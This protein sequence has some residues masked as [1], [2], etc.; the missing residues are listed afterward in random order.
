[1]S[2]NNVSGVSKFNLWAES[3]STS[4]GD[5]ANLY[6]N[7]RH[8]VKITVGLSFALLDPSVSGPSDDEVRKGLSL[9]NNNDG[10][11]LQHLII[12]DKG[13]YTAIYEPGQVTKKTDVK[14][15]D[16]QHEIV[17]YLASNKTVNPDIA[18]EEVSVRLTYTDA[19]GD[20]YTDDMSAQGQ[21]YE[22]DYVK[23]TCYAQKKYTTSDFSLSKEEINATWHPNSGD[24]TTDYTTYLL[25][26]KMSGDY[27][28]IQAMS[29]E[30]ASQSEVNINYDHCIGWMAEKTSAVMWD[31]C[32]DC[33]AITSHTG[34]GKQTYAYDLYAYYNTN[35]GSYSGNS[36]GYHSVTI[37][38]GD[39]EFIFISTYI[40]YKAKI[41]S[42]SYLEYHYFDTYDQFGNFCVIRMLLDS[43]DKQVFPSISNVE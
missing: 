36:V 31:S 1:M 33:F 35:P 6:V 28:R 30:N 22:K 41:A 20:T 16:Y 26:L 17:F 19:N 9:I 21:Y 40:T 5:D 27:Y 23:V 15:S 38:Q 8:Q 13:D 11:E 7:D 34:I 18:S 29:M 25:R 10:G 39:N 32:S 14:G 42:D 24:H 3:N 43:T 2:W 12:R 37:D 4:E